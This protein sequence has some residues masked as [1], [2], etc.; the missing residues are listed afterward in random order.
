MY[1]SSSISH[2]SQYLHLHFIL[3][4]PLLTVVLQAA[5]VAD[6]IDILALENLQECEI[7]TSY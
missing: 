5:Q 1:I 2:I 3:L 7:N 6:C 4:C